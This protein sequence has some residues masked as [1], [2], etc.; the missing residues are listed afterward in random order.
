[1]I[2]ELASR[3]L[4][5]PGATLGEAARQLESTRVLQ[6]FTRSEIATHVAIVDAQGR[7]LA[8]V[9]EADPGTGV[10]I[11]EAHAPIRGSGEVR[12]RKATFGMVQ[13]MSDVAPKVALLALILVRSFAIPESACAAIT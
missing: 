2:A 4:D 6:A 10:Q 1:M 9:G 12:V 3:A 8:A 11:V 13:L 5:A 7:S